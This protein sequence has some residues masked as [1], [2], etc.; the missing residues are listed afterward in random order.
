[1]FVFRKSS[2]QSFE[3]IQTGSELYRQH[4]VNVLFDIN[5]FGSSDLWLIMSALAGSG[6][7]T[8]HTCKNK[9]GRNN[10]RFV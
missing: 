4:F 1:L 5:R 10:V 2:I 3:I 9:V 8:R 7:D 6:V